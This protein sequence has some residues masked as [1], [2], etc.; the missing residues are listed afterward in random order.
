MTVW[1][2]YDLLIRL[3]NEIQPSIERTGE[4]HARA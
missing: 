3:F 1:P 2:M 4:I